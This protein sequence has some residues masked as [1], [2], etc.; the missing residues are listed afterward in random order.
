MEGQLGLKNASP[1]LL[2][3]EETR[4]FHAGRT[5]KPEHGHQTKATLGDKFVARKEE[6]V[7]HFIYAAVLQLRMQQVCVWTST[8]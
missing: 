2:L 1:G 4:A 6:G 7:V 3:F 8:L 5:L